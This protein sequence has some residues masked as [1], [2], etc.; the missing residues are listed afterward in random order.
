[1]SI[2]RPPVHFAACDHIDPGDFLFQDRCLSCTKLRI[3]EI[4]RRQLT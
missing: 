3:S 2:V 4:A 1:M